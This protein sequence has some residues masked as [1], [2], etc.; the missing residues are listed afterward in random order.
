M[1]LDLLVQCLIVL[2]AMPASSSTLV[3]IFKHQAIFKIRALFYAKLYTKGMQLQ[4]RENPAMM[5]TSWKR[6]PLM[7]D[8]QGMI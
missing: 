3:M 8:L 6:N 4:G 7:N 2:T 5:A 1:S